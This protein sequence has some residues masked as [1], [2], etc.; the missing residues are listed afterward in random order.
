[1][2]EAWR[3]AIAALAVALAGCGGRPESAHKPPPDPPYVPPPESC[4][5]VDLDH[6]TSF[7][8]CSTGGGIFGQWVVDDQGLPAYD[9]GLDENA[10]PRA[11]FD[12][13][14][15]DADG[16]MLDRR[17]H[18]AAFGNRRINAMAY[19]D[20]YI[21]VVDQDH[22]V[23]Y[24]DKFDASQQSFAGGFSYLDD[25][26]S[27]WCTAYKWRPRGSKTT[28]RFGMGYA[29]SG[30]DYRDI[31]VTR[32]TTAPP[33]D[34]PV[35]LSDVTLENHGSSTKK[36]RYYEYW[37]VG[38]R[39]ITINWVV[40]GSA[41]HL[42]PETA[43]DQRDAED[44]MFD[45]SVSYDAAARL[46]GLRRTY[47]G[48][49]PRPAADAPSP[50]DY[51]PADPFLAELVGTPSDVY[52]DQ[53]SFFGKGGVGAPDM[54]SKR[55]H[56][57]GVAG[58]ALGKKQSGLGQPRTFVIRSDVTLAPGESKTLRF[59]YGY[60][61]IGQPYAID[62]KW[63]DPA[64][65]PRADYA[66]TLE[67]RLFYFGADRDPF[68]HRE[69]AW[70][71]Y[72]VE[73]SVG[74][75]DYFQGH[76]VPQG[77][78]YLYLHGADGA[79]RDLALFAVPLVY[80]DPALAKEELEL[81]MRIQY[82]TDGHFSYAF[83]GN[84][85]LD[86][87][88]VHKDPSDL[89]IFFAWALGEYLG[90]TGDLAF[91]DEKVPYWPRATA[92]SATVFDHLQRALHHQL[93]DIG[94]GAHGLIRLQTGDWSDGIALEASDY[95]LAVQK[96]ESVPDTQMAAAVFPP[97]AD[98]IEQRDATLAAELRTAVQGYRTALAG[99]WNGKFFYRAY[100]GDNKPYGS[101]I[102]LE[103]Q[104][105]A[106]IGGT[107]NSPG[108]RTTLI[109]NIAA[110]LDDPSPTG[111]TLTPGGEVWPA[112][113]APLTWGYALSDPARAW[114]HLAKNTLAAHAL[115]FPDVLVRHLER[116]RRDELEERRSLAEPGHADARLPRPEQQPALDA[117][118]RRAARG[119]RGC[120]RQGARD[121]AAR[122]R[123]A[124]LAEV[125][126]R[127]SVRARRRAGRQL[128]PHW[129]EHAYGERAGGRAYRDGRAGRRARH[130]AARRH[131]RH[132]QRRRRRP[133]LPRCNGKVALT[134]D[135][136]AGSPPA[137][138]LGSSPAP[139]RR[140]QRRRPR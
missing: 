91:L 112:I 48:K 75:R 38:R 59:A 111:A 136:T 126:A 9:Y 21:E 81:M 16:N 123:A 132:F 67:P 56:G 60:A 54:V 110:Q 107:F 114:K 61:P 93:D 18:W 105:W 133:D 119:R 34:A 83:Q 130:R 58:G 52:T 20:G 14:E 131:Q 2:A 45:E 74:R 3:R 66:K 47:T 39:P 33:G 120:R 138:A 11:A 31:A 127:R 19:N 65:D 121:F 94:T 80:T 70:H 46:L 43:R 89:S 85:M 40:S 113:S 5:A 86:D 23:E 24:L 78:A 109:D 124:V 36:L 99:T 108:D 101:S 137:R 92:P 63:R 64:Y 77:S 100:F 25:G 22:G 50:K 97:I 12:V 35:V 44:G 104:I 28:R 134:V 27:T 62:K 96:G 139:P 15:V 53:A 102:D 71:S 68:L 125:G 117:D 116:P 79:A 51:Y 1:M 135:R 57:E 69:M 95:N 82:P 29:E 10:D 129:S 103:S 37:D 90:A 42:A 4:D 88:G 13:S 6:I 98:L 115:A 72:Q 84:G 87:A 30:M 26:K 55:T 140:W 8:P 41:F 106:L 128:S 17:D 7:A 76:V 49:D 32:R 118:P 122:T 73:T